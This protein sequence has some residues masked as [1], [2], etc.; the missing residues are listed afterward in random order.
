MSAIEILGRNDIEIK[1]EIKKLKKDVKF[2]KKTFLGDDVV[3]S[4]F[5]TII[6][7]K[8][9]E[10][11]THVLKSNLSGQLEIV[12]LIHVD[13]YLSIT[14]FSNDEAHRIAK[15]VKLSSDDAEFIL[16]SERELAIKLIEQKESLI[17][18]F[19]QQLKYM[20]EFL[21]RNKQA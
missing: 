7:V 5:N 18:S 17:E 16:L 9:N 19:E 13:K 3:V 10:Q 14:R 20:K 8:M 2:I 15:E 4:K 21:E 1:D 12:M 11:L 6:G